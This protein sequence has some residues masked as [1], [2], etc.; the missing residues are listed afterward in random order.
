MPPV[1]LC[2]ITIKLM[3]HSQTT[4]IKMFFYDTEII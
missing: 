4:R 3:S 1:L 2:T